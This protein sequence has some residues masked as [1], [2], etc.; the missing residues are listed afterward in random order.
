MRSKQLIK[1]GAE[2]GDRSEATASVLASM[3]KAGIP[4][5]EIIKTFESEAIGE[6]YREKGSGRVQWLKDEMRQVQRICG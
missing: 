2:K 4:E 6:K 3:V 5:E 1:N